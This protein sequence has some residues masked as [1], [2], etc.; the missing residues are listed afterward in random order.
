V[1]SHPPVIEQP[2]QGNHKAGE[3]AATLGEHH[4][5]DRTDLQLMAGFFPET[6]EAM[7]N[8]LG[9]TKAKPGRISG[10]AGADSAQS[11]KIEEDWNIAS[12][13]NRQPLGNTDEYNRNNP[14][15]PVIETPETPESSVSAVCQ[16]PHHRRHAGVGDVN[17]T[18][19]NDNTQGNCVTNLG[20]GLLQRNHNGLPVL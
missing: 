1:V 4:A 7:A 5:N 3:S 18:V 16:K 12:P 2:N 20:F 11:G 15:T 19:G 9:N 8:D 17:A 6:T 14:A 13:T 10:S